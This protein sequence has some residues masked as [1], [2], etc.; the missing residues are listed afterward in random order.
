M[1]PRRDAYGKAARRRDGNDGLLA[2]ATPPSGQ[3]L[4]RGPLGLNAF[5]GM[6]VLAG[7]DVVDEAAAAGEIVVVADPAHQHRVA[8]GLLEMAARTFDAAVSCATPQ[9]LRVGCIPT[10]AH[11][12][13]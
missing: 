6:G 11:S 5:G 8:D 1:C 9:L 4:Q 12:A 7:D 13:P 2:I 3:R 10:W